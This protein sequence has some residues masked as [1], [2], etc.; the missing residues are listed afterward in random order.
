[1]SFTVD[2]FPEELIIPIKA[3]TDETRRKILLSLIERDAASYSQMQNGFQI[4]KGTLNHHLHKL[5]SAGLIRN[6]SIYSPVNPYNSYYA[7]TDF[8]RK[9]VEGF[10]QTLEPKIVRRTMTFQG[11]ATMLEEVIGASASQSEEKLLEKIAP[12]QNMTRS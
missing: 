1:M 10:R 11:T 4:K 3:L 8:G 12:L 5:V 9:L 6:F 7:I 2:D